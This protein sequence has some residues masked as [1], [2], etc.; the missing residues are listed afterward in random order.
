MRASK[1]M[2][3]LDLSN[4]KAKKNPKRHLGKVRLS[5]KIYVGQIGSCVCLYIFRG[6]I[7]QNH[8]QP[9][10]YLFILQELKALHVCVF[11]CVCVVRVSVYTQTHTDMGFSSC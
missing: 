8:H 1:E 4:G 10:I 7:S 5:G 11:V 3:V 2:K 6:R 9:L